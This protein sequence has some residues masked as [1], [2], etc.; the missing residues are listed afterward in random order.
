MAIAVALCLKQET[1]RRSSK[2]RYKRRPECSHE[3]RMIDPRLSEP[4]DYKIYVRL[5][6]PSFNELFMMALEMLLKP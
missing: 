2:E 3:N 1:I 6:G 4:N 5:D